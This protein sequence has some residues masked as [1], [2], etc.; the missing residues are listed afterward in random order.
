MLESYVVKKALQPGE[1]GY[2]G[3]QPETSTISQ[4]DENEI[5]TLEIVREYTTIPIP[6]LI[7]QGDG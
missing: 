7:Y 4:R 2:Y 3:Y 1:L 5:R 6:K